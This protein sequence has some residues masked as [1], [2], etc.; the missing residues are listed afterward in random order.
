MKDCIFCKIIKKEI[1]ADIIT[2]DNNFMAFL[3]RNPANQGH[4][5]IIPK[6]HAKWIWNVEKYGEYLEFTK[7]I[8]KTLQK[9]MKT[10]WVIM[11]VAGDEVPHAHI[12]LV[13]R[14]ENDGFKFETR[15]EISKEEMK[16]ILEKIKNLL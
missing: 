6:K 5:L 13:P 14:W 7:K 2:E 11:V 15:K 10:E 9:A 8:A 1:S 12:H 3:D 16:N 4:T